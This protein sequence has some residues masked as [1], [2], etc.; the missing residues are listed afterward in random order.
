MFA[1][2]T[3]VPVSRVGIARRNW[4]SFALQDYL[5]AEYKKLARLESPSESRNGVW[6]Q[7]QASYWTWI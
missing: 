2:T 1:C 4:P 3:T 6:A 5:L 7:Q